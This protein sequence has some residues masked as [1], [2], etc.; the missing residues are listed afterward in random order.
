M[1]RMQIYMLTVKFNA[2]GFSCVIKL[3]AFS[4][5]IF[6]KLKILFVTQL[7]ECPVRIDFTIE[8]KNIY[9]ATDIWQMSELLL[10]SSFIL[11]LH[12]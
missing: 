10:F 8:K 1:S 9:T 5:L 3:F 2:L 12:L 4:S 11:Q 6:P 7:L